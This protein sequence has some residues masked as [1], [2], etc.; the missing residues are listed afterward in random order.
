MASTPSISPSLRQS[1]RASLSSISSTTAIDKEALSQALDEIHSAACQTDALTTFNEFTT[2]PASSTVVNETKGIT[3]DLQGGIAGLYSRLRASVGNTRDT[4]DASP[5]EVVPENPGKI[6]LKTSASTKSSPVTTRDQIGDADGGSEGNSESGSR[7]VPFKGTASTLSDGSFPDQKSTRVSSGT[8]APSS[9][10]SSLLLRKNAPSPSDSESIQA[11]KLKDVPSQSVG[12]GP[13]NNLGHAYAQGSA[14]GRMVKPA[15]LKLK[16][17]I[18]VV[19]PAPEKAK[20]PRG[21]RNPELTNL[22]E[23]VLSQVAPTFGD[24]EERSN[25]EQTHLFIKTPDANAMEE[26]DV[27][28]KSPAQPRILPEKIDGKVDDKVLKHMPADDN[29]LPFVRL[30]KS[31]TQQHLEIPTRTSLAPP[32]ISKNEDVS[33]PVISRTS[34]IDTSAKPATSDAKNGPQM[35]KRQKSLPNSV[36][37]QMLAGYTQAEPQNRSSK[38]MKVFSQVKNKVLSKEYW[39]KDENAR[40][41][42]N[43]GEPF[44]TFRRKH[45]CR[46]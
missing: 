46:E 3:S 7:S 22:S 30:E 6:S 27:V 19:Q 17:E 18:E 15:D 25:F 31:A 41:C 8:R 9:V 32:L 4:R 26:A 11:P 37:S 16:K 43:C 24:D 21:L 38:T 5:A 1:R 13:A 39:M 35:P 42:F 36:N 20:S 45:H 40:D 14:A 34:S 12:S 44:T 23:A 28:A 29:G 10:S 33:S 2:P